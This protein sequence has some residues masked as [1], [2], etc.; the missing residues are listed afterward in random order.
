M[1]INSMKVNNFRSFLHLEEIRLGQ[2]ATIIGQNDTGKSN[3]LKAIDLF[4]QPRPKPDISDIYDKA[5]S[6]EN[7]E[8]EISFSDL[9]SIITIEEGVETTFA[10]ENLLDKEDYLRLKKIFP[11]SDLAKYSVQINT[12]DY[13]DDIYSSLTMLKEKDLNE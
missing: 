12:Y 1:N 11:R 9:P 5:P 13:S 2:L 10:N 4:L 7:I 3:I 6:E 8:I